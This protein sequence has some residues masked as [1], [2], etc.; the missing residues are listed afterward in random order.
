MEHVAHIT[1]GI[2]AVGDYDA[3]FFW[4]LRTHERFPIAS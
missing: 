3:D 4:Q 1:L 2:A